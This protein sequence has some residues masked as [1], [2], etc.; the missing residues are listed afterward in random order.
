MPTYPADRHTNRAIATVAAV[1]GVTFALGGI[2]H[3]WFEVLQGDVPTG[4]IFIN[5]I[6]P[7]HVQWAE[8]TDPAMTLIPSFLWTGLA[9]IVVSLVIAV[10]SLFFLTGR[11]G[12]GVYLGLFILMTLVGGGI[13]HIPFFISSWAYATRIRRPLTW[14]QRRWPA[15]RRAAIGRPWPVLMALS[16]IGFLIGLVTSVFGIPGID[17][18]QLILSICWS[19]LGAVFVLMH[20]AFASATAADLSARGPA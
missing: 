13:G 3:G 5:S 8:G 6:A 16:S 17:S 15:E 4:G 2:T 12:P 14:W 11:G 18:D 1:M 7:P 9:A 10:W 20:L 19:F